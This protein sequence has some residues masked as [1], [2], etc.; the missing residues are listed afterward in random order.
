[1]ITYRE[2]IINRA[3]ELIEYFLDFDEEKGLDKILFQDYL[4]LLTITQ[5]IKKILIF[6]D[7]KI[8]RLGDKIECDSQIND[9]SFNEIIEEW[10]ELDRLEKI[11]EDLI[12][13]LVSTQNAWSVS[14]KH[15]DQKFLEQI[16]DRNDEKPYSKI[17]YFRDVF[18]IFQ[19]LV[20]RQTRG[21]DVFKFIK[22]DDDFDKILIDKNFAEEC[23]LKFDNE[24][25]GFKLVVE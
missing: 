16:N 12:K 22:H 14:K 25:F 3:N 4:E 5:E 2:K 13:R 17:E 6:S 8:Q 23:N 1:M 10:N 15:L 19:R 20:R 9:E 7:E 21:R 18:L 24:F 11:C